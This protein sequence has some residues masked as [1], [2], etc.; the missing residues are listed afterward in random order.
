ML[1]VA[2]QGSRTAAQRSAGSS[3]RP[4]HALQSL[5]AGVAV[6]CV[7]LLAL[8]CT[9]S[10]GMALGQALA[11]RS[12]P[13]LLAGATLMLAGQLLLRHTLQYNFE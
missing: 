2:L 4:L 13:S 9:S 12:G 11:L 1:Q 3:R 10:S 5:S 8:G 7:N 6:L